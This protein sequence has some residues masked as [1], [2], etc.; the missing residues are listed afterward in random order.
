MPQN[1]EGW[2]QKLG[3]KKQGGV[4]LHGQDRKRGLG[5]NGLDFF[6]KSK[7]F[8]L[9]VS[10]DSLKASVNLEINHHL[11]YFL[12]QVHLDKFVLLRAFD[13]VFYVT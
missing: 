13:N 7:V 1:V 5:E 10:L 4:E 11:G 12:R 9:S 8:A 2:N 3:A 6:P